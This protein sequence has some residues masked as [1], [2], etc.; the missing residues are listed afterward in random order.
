MKENLFLAEIAA[1]DESAFHSFFNFFYEELVSYA[2][3]HL[4]DQ[5]ESEDLVQE[6]FI[7]IWENASNLQVHTNMRSYMYSMVR[8]R[9]IN[10]LKK[11]SV[12]D[13]DH[14]IDLNTIF[15]DSSVFPVFEENEE[16]VHSL[17]TAVINSFPE[18]MR[19]IFLL[20]IKHNYKYQQIAEHSG[21][22]VNTVK[23]QLKRA[24]EKI[25]KMVFSSFFF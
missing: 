24:K 13:Y 8:N 3:K 14:A 11:L 12:V 18:K 9:C 23:T 15:E 19:E 7:Y 20:R 6:A 10:R 4:Y 5:A 25:S 17:I 21:V 22:S 1:G 2:Y 16:D